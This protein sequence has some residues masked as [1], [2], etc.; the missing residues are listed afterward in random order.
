MLLPP[1]ILLAV[2]AITAEVVFRIQRHGIR[3][4]THPLETA[5]TRFVPIDCKPTGPGGELMTPNCAMFL[6]GVELRTN[7]RGMNDH[8]FDEARIGFRVLVLGDSV[9]LAAGVSRGAAYHDLLEERFN[10]ELGTAG[11][12]EFY[13]HAGDGR[14]TDQQVGDLE[15]A[16]TSLPL[17][18]ALV[19]VT[20]S[21]FWDSLLEPQ[22]NCGPGDSNSRLT[23]EEA[24]F[25]KRRVR[26]KNFVT[27]LLGNGER[28]TGLWI[29]RVPQDP[30]R[31]LWRNLGMTDADRERL[32]LV[33]QKAIGAF[34]LC[35]AR[36]RQ[37]ADEADVE[38][39]WMIAHYTPNPHTETMR[40][41]L[42]GLGEPVVS[43][44]DTHERFDD[45]ADLM[46]YRGDPHPS[47][48]AHASF[49]ESLYPYLDEIG[50][51]SLA[52]SSLARSSHEAESQP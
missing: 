20:P 12:V 34:K 9:S 22:G 7:S 29:F 4:L 41:A 11:F 48:M 50:W 38:L 16:V 25:Q 30:L 39:A 40:R 35:A 15:K 17:D 36:M 18:A 3:G 26:G 51:V 27:K 2:V 45:D 49:A 43:L 8:E 10:H 37:I 23:R 24:R 21:D 6:S 44:M 5:P 46:I 32:A 52:R 13:N 28:A 31:R 47:A 1:L 42:E 33:E 14:S 19:A